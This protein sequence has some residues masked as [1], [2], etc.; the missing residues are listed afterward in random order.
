MSD[1]MSDARAMRSAIDAKQAEA[2]KAWAAFTAKKDAILASGVDALS[3][4]EAFTELDELGKS[5]DS[6]VDEVKGMEGRWALLMKDAPI[7]EGGNPFAAGS[8][9]EE[10]AGKALAQ[11][12]LDFG[13]RFV[14]SEVYAQL[15]ADGRLDRMELPLGTT[16][17]VKMADAVEV[18][19]L[20]TTSAGGAAL[21]RNDRIPT[22]IDIPQP[23]LN[24]LDVIQFGTTDSDT[25]EWVEE[26]TYTNAA[27]E[28]A[29]GTAAPESALAY[30]TKTSTV[31][32]ITHFIPATK[33]MLADAGQLR[34]LIDGRMVYGVRNR[35]QKQVIAGD[36][37]G[38]NLRGIVNVVGIL[39]Q[40]RGA[41]SRADAV[42]KAI[43]KIRIQAEGEAVPQYVGL[44]PTDLET[45]QLEKNANGDYFLGG[46]GQAGSSRTI[47]G[48]VPVV[49][50]HFTTG[51]PVVGD[52]S[53]AN[54]WVREG[55]SL[56]ASDSHSTF[57][58]ERKVAIL[59]A[60]R[61]AFGVTQPKAFCT[62]TS[63]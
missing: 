28:T 62:V 43:T 9:A 54:V 55:L 29:E 52:Y 10:E 6:V 57:F 20:L 45:L 22:F 8:R 12:G 40:A 56:A 48:L 17:A 46:P 30:T 16:A 7:S 39:T 13:D 14:K 2:G 42:H 33:K 44:H 34:T 23:P 31:Q 60:M 27:A 35:L 61:A 47:W 53:F 38:S 5:Y 19:T 24:V 4:A 18:K 58:T 26:S 36:A 25:V 41:D 59:A 32:E 21:F 50:T 1:K 3:N 63:F 15:K 51:T 11:G 49:S 37:T